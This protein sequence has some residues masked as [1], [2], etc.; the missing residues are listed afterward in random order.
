MAGT[1]SLAKRIAFAAVA[2]PAVAAI[3]YV[4]G[5]ALAALLAAAAAL[6]A[7]ELGGFAQ[8]QGIGL[9]RPLGAMGA[10]ALP[11][12][13]AAAYRGGPSCSGGEVLPFVALTWFLAVL[14]AA[15]LQL[16]PDRRPLSAVAITVFAA[17]YAG[18]L[19]SF[20]IVLRESVGSSPNRA[21]EGTAV[22]FF[23]LV[24]T[25]IGDTAAY[26]GGVAIGGPK[27]A[28]VLSPNKTWAG[29]ACGLAG[30][31][32]A[33]AAYSTWVLS[34]V[35]HGLTFSQIV[36]AGVAISA[37]GQAGDLT[38]SLFKREAGVKDSSALIPGHGGV[39]DRLDS[40]YFALPVAS[41]LLFVFEATRR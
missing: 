38:E 39:L 34:R 3:A 12:A 19:P 36:V 10:A 27:L 13:V 28:P 20:A 11:L 18:G 25:W 9:N 26:A 32:V 5:W 6:G 33:A 17:L 37:A 30:T 35:R 22:L 15:V 4:G 23:P 14:L 7:L 29:A 40:L 24:L 21:L 2:I 16:A 8:S 31:L 41:L 1:S